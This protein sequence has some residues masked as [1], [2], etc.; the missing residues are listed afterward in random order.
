MQQN[1]QAIL[2]ANSR[3]TLY[4]GK[5]ILLEH[6]QRSEKLLLSITQF[7]IAIPLDLFQAFEHPVRFICRPHERIILLAQISHSTSMLTCTS[8]C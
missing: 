2:F 1:A 5:H 7:L 3:D 4:F 8:S 6:V